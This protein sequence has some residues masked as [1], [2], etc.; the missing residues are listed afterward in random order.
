MDEIFIAIEGLLDLITEFILDRAFDK[1]KTLKKRLPYIIF[2]ILILS[3][4]IACLLIG[5]IYLVKNNNLIG[6]ILLAFAVTFITLLVYPF[7]KYK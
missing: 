2:Y 1:K 6:I 7:I 4:I 3:L 5:G